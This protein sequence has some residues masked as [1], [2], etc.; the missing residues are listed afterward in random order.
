MRV[1]STFGVALATLSYLSLAFRRFQSIRATHQTH[2]MSHQIFD[3]I[4]QPNDLL[5]MDF[6]SKLSG[7]GHTLFCRSI[8]PPRNAVEFGIESILRTL[9]D[10]SPIVEYWWRDEWLSLEAHKDVDEYRSRY[11]N[12]TQYPHNAHVLYLSI[13]PE[14][15]GPTV[16]LLEDNNS[17]F[18]ST[19]EKKFV[20]MVI[21]PA[22]TNRLLRF[23]GNISH[24]VPRPVLAYFDPV[25]GGSN[26]ELWIRRRPQ[27]GEMDNPDRRSV[28]L[29]NTWSQMP[30]DIS[31]DAPQVSLT[32]QAEQKVQPIANSLDYWS[33]QQTL[34]YGASNDRLVRLKIGMFAFSSL[35]SVA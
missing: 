21:A 8:H 5:E 12:I 1:K 10:S 24:C 35:V 31:A 34:S 6:Q 18:T 29:F 19:G 13:G 20:K 30:L 4:F 14:V 9:K 22:K 16:L 26:T 27:E 17:I 33:F 7:M 23:D 3:N 15:K 2:Y 11:E 28:L 25:E 32:R